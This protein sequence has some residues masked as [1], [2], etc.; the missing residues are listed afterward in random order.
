MRKLLFVC[1]FLVTGISYLMS[2]QKGDT[3]TIGKTRFVIQSD[4]LIANPGFENDFTGWTDATSSAAT[5]S[6]TYFSIAGSGGVDNSKYLI[7]TTN[8]SSTAAGSIGTSWSIESGKTYYFSY[9]VKYLNTTTAAGTSTLL[10]VSLTNAPNTATES[11]I[12][13]DTAKING[14]GMWTKNAVGFTNTFPYGYVMARFRNLNN[15]FGFDNFALHEAYEIPDTV[16]L[17]TIIVQAQALY[18][19]GTVGTQALSEAI[20]NAQT[21]LT[22]TSAIEVRTA[23]S[24]L[25]TA[26]FNF[27]LANAS[28]A[29]PLDMTSYIVNPSF[30]SAFTGW[31]NTGFSAQSNAY[32]PGKDGTYYIE[33]WV[34]R[35]TK[36]SDVAVQQ[37]ITNL[38]NG[39]YTLS[40]VCGNIQQTGSGSSVNVGNPQTG[41]TLFAGI[42]TLKVDTVKNRS[43]SFFVFDNQITF[44]LKTVSATGNWVAADNFHLQ[45]KGYDVDAIKSYLQ[46][47]VDTSNVLLAKKMQA[48]VRTELNSVVSLAQSAIVN[49]SITKDSLSSVIVQIQTGIAD[50]RTSIAA[51]SDLQTAINT[52]TILYGT[53][54]GN[55]ASSLKTAIDAAT[56]TVNDL[57]ATLNQLSTAKASLD[58]AILVYRLANAT[59][60]APTVVTNPVC[61]RGAT[62]AFGRSTITGFAVTDLL[63]HGFCW[64]TSPNPTVMDN[65][66]TKYFSHNGYIYRMENLTPSTVYYVR[67]YAITKNYVVGYGDVV[68][69]ITIIKGNVSYTYNFG[70]P[71]D[72]NARINSSLTSAVN[73]YNNLTSIQGLRITCSY[74]SGTPTAD[75]GYGGSMRVGPNSAYQKTGT[76]MH[77]MGH[78]IG[79]GTHWVWYGPTSPLRDAGSRGFWLGDRA[80][81]VVRFFENDIA[82]SVYGDAIHDWPKGFISTAINYGING[83]QEDNGSELLYT[84][85]ALEKQA[86]GEDGLAPTGGFAT[87]AYTFDIKD[88]AKYYIK[89]E[90][91]ISG[92][93]NSF[94]IQSN[95]GILSNRQMTPTQALANDSAAWTIS[96]NPLNAYYTIK[97][98]ATGR[99][100]TYLSSGTGGIGLILRTG[101]NLSTDYFQF[102]GAR[103]KTQIGTG[104]DAFVTKGYWM[105]HPEATMSSAC[106]TAF[107]TAGVTGCSS[108]NI[109]NTATTQRWLLL[110]GDEVDQFNQTQM[111]A[112][113]NKILTS[114]VSIYTENERI[115]IKNIELKSNI[116]I[117]DITGKILLQAQ[118]VVSSFTHILPKGLYLVVINSSQNYQTK[119]VIVR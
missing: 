103:V 109:A 37:T 9:N 31:T 11:S 75:C 69:V 35:G 88:N 42:Y 117:Y 26:M 1:L 46:M 51:Y 30:E 18:S 97:N 78:A 43:L 36:V 14:G 21:Y 3:V 115:Y 114:T 5:L 111:A 107:G 19:T 63:E 6:S 85:N 104:S 110:S 116:T 94:L 56:P 62:Q 91:S 54:T 61:L 101:A 41:A 24:D 87:P 2:Q 71:A 10:K 99:Y 13:I 25:K 96:F 34:S 93:N 112:G 66:T 67:A 64:S 100:F 80:N 33:K 70:G 12:L 92:L 45:Y 47:Q 113:V 28:L 60:T 89:S 68:K 74:G 106:L 8:A 79:V 40:A 22:S 65:R 17:R 27:K 98:V 39:H 57:N 7:G 52:A 55:E 4:N 53:G 90:D 29:N 119:K 108:F 86:L 72:A 105:V 20:T 82:G 50:A 58:N 32:L 77:E 48:N 118:D 76:I 44:G 59:G 95:T 83:A 81:E 84:A 73:Y 38:P 49:V 23:I 16:S 15:L 102:M